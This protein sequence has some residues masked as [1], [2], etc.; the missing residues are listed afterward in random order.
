MTWGLVNSYQ[1]TDSDKYPTASTIIGNSYN[2][3]QSLMAVMQHFKWTQFALLYSTND[4]QHRCRYI[5]DDIEN[6]VNQEESIYI[7][8]QRSLVLNTVDNIKV[9]LNLVKS[10]A[11]SKCLIINSEFH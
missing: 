6:V 2:L 11:R 9:A 3:G 4:A 10:R 7:S 5:K 1:L 8:F